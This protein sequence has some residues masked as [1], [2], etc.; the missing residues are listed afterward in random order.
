MWPIHVI[1]VLVLD[2]GFRVVSFFLSF[3]PISFPVYVN[4]RL[5][6]ED[7]MGRDWG[8]RNLKEIVFGNN[9]RAPVF[10]PK[11]VEKIDLN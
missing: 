1:A 4:F 11:M 8:L 7:V 9:E 5:S 3:S 2:L 6:V 10:T